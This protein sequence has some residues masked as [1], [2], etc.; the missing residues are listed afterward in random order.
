MIADDQ[1]KIDKAAELAREYEYT[2]GS[3]PQC[4]TAALYEKLDVGSPDVTMEKICKQ[5]VR[6]KAGFI[7]SL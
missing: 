2:I 3:C 5:K 4:V 6:L 1:S 7:Q